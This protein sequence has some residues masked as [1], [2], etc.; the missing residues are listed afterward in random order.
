MGNAADRTVSLLGNKKKHGNRALTNRHYLEFILKVIHDSAI[1]FFHGHF[2]T[3][4]RYFIWNNVC[5]RRNE[6]AL[7]I[8]D[9]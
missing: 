5:R 1:L 9:R 8:T 3:Y 6:K 7:A 2:M 4:L